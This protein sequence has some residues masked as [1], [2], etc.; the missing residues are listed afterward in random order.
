MLQIYRNLS[1][2]PNFSETIFINF[3][4]K[5][6]DSIYDMGD[7]TF[8]FHWVQGTKY[9]AHKACH[10]KISYLHKVTK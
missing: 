9:S 10:R 4:K 7:K 1:T 2:L 3:S 6:F 8:Y 5:L